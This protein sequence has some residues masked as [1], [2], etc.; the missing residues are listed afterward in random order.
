MKRGCFLTAWLSVAIGSAQFATAQ[1]DGVNQSNSPDQY[2]IA[3]LPLVES[4]DSRSPSGDETSIEATSFDTASFDSTSFDARLKFL[5]EE[6][7]KNKDAAAKAKDEGPTY[8]TVKI[9][10]RLQLD[11]WAF[12]HVGPG[13]GFFENPITGNDPDDRFAFRRLRLNFR[14][15]V[16]ET[17]MYRFDLEFAEPRNPG[18]RDAWIGFRELPL[19]QT[20][21][22]GNQ[23]RPIGLDYWNN[24]NENVFLER[25]MVVEAFNEDVR[26]LG[27]QSYGV[28]ESESHTW[29]F[30]VFNLANT[31]DAGAYIGDSLQLSANARLTGNPWYDESSGGRGYFHWA[32]AGMFARPDGDAPAGSANANEARFRTR[33]EVRSNERWLNTDRIAGAESY[34]IFGLEGLLNVGPIQV[35]SEYQYNWLQRDAGTDLHFHGAYVYLSYFLTGE[36]IPYDRTKSA[37]GVVKPFENFFLVNRC[38]SGQGCGWGAWQVAIRYS[39]LDLTDQDVLGGVGSNVTLALNWHWTQT[40]KLQINYVTGQIEDHAPVG[41]FTSGSYSI[42]GTRFLAYF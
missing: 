2:R 26:R 32:V 12:P 5:E 39:Y 41:G 9:N 34:E 30:G 23:K 40:S 10:G 20:L 31:A 7:A 21:L 33:A 3:R 4:A 19:L 8:P 11:Y 6:Y 22:I 42:I 36:H 35:V 15:D 38:R 16:S 17:M 29:Q 14:G 27:I 1:Y 37:I 25:P 13:I 18:Y 24:S 28:S